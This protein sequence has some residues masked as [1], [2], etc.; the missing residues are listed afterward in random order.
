LKG[1]E[2]SGGE[3]MAT[4]FEMS[5]TGSSKNLLGAIAVL[6][7]HNIN[8]NTIATAKVENRFVVKFL[9]GSEE[10][11]RRM[12]MKADLQYKDRPVLVVSMFNK[13]GQWLKVAR[14]LVDAGIEISASYLMGQKG[15]TQSFVF[16]VSDYEKAKRICT[17]IAECSVDR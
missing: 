8:L 10:E 12:L 3:I 11:V 14:A 17:R 7:E 13:P 4:E 5:F 16:A 9:S 2:P 15:D 1:L 6:S